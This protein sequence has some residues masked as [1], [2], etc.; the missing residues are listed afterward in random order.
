MR[1][2]LPFLCMLVLACWLPATEHCALEAAG[3]F[4]K[5]CSDGCTSGR[6]GSD[7]GCGTVENGAYKPSADVVKVPTPDLF[8]C[9]CHLCLQLVALDAAREITP[10]SSAS[11]ERPQDWVSKWHFVRRAAPSPRAPSLISA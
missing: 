10:A 6:L 7:D 1:R 2:L 3:I 4:P 11:Y 5:Q 8:V 9:A